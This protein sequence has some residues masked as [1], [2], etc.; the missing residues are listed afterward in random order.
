MENK[1]DKVVEFLEFRS[2]FTKREWAELNQAVEFR[3]KEKAD[4]MLI[5]DF[6]IKL[7]TERIKL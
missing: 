1:E 4:N 5:T 2:K 7:I 3:I 6:D